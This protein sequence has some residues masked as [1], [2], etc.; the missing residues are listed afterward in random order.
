M[1]FRTTLLQTGKNTT[2]IRVPDDVVESL[3]AGKRPKVTV[4]IKDHSY[5]NSIAVMDGVYMVGVSAEHRSAVG[6]AGGDEVDVDIALDA[7]PREVSVPEDFAAALRAEPK[8]HQFFD[9]LSY[10]DR[11]W[12]VLSVEGAK[13]AET[14]QRRI[15]KSV[16]MLRAGRAR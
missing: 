7:A 16:D 5:R 9:T 10:T 1:R 13:G 11:R 4:T 3:G 15:G 14:R 6:V 2:G 8:A 12:H